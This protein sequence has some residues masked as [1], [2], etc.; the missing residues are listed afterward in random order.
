MDAVERLI[1]DLRSKDQ[2]GAG[3]VEATEYGVPNIERLTRLDAHAAVIRSCNI[4][5]IPGL[6]QHPA[7]ALATTKAAFPRLPEAELRRWI[8]MRSARTHAFLDL[9]RSDRLTG[10]FVVGQ[11]AIMHEASGDAHIRQLEHLLDVIDAHSQI[12]VL[13]LPFH[14]VPPAFTTQLF[15]WAFRG[16]G[17]GDTAN[18]TTPACAYTESAAGGTYT[19]RIDDLARMRSAWADLVNA[20]MGPAESRSYIAEVLGA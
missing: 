2:W 20:S 17:S 6:L 12:Q 19:T 18:R 9:L 8:L 15:L 10:L 1:W 7:Y 4:L 5:Y 13:I 3:R 16:E 14:T 11:Q